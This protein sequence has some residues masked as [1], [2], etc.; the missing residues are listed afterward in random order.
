MGTEYLVKIAITLSPKFNTC[1]PTI[2][3]SVPGQTQ[4]FTLKTMS[5]FDFEFQACDTGFLEID[6]FNKT[7]DHPD[8]AVMIDRIELF[9]I[10][11]PKFV[12]NGVYTPKYPEPWYSQQ[13]VQPQ[14]KISNVTYLGWN[15]T[16]RIDFDVPVFTWI[17][18]IQNLGWIY[19]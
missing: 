11:D 1:P 9:G 19:Q 2:V 6:F 4:Q 18:K 7:N 15:G 3:M 14:K 12:W 13:C 17:H 8:M 10:S 5:R 16:W